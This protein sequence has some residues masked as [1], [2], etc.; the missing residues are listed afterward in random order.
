MVFF[1]KRSSALGLAGAAVASQ[2]V[3]VTPVQSAPVVATPVVTPI[4]QKTVVAAPVVQKTV[5]A[6]PVYYKYEIPSFSVVKSV[7]T[8]QISKTVATV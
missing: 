8:V 3:V 1:F 6:P 5:V 7:P 2:S 4:V